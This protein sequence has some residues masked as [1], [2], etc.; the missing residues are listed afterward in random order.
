MRKPKSKNKSIKRNQRVKITSRKALDNSKYS[1][2]GRKP[3]HFD[4][5]ET[6][7]AIIVKTRRKNIYINKK[8]LG[9]RFRRSGQK[10]DSLQ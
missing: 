4:R 9:G 6:D 8:R 7:R 5:A 1:N 2:R 10:T 3:G